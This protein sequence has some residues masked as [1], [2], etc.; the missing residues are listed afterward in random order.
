MTTLSRHIRFRALLPRRLIP[1]VLLRSGSLMTEQRDKQT[2]D[3]PQVTCRDVAKL[4]KSFF[5]FVSVDED[6]IVEMDSYDDRN[7]YI[8]GV[9]EEQDQ[10][11]KGSFTL[12]VTNRRESANTAL[13]EAQN[14]FMLYLLEGG[15]AAPRPL[16]ARGGGFIVLHSIALPNCMEGDATYA[17]RVFTFL[18]GELL[19]KVRQNPSLLVE[20]GK[21]IGRM[22]IHL[23]VSVLAEL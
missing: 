15:F 1:A 3:K 19:V 12:K 21:A 10:K 22:N 5:P 9:V 16:Q 4:A 11:T 17:I 14:D 23:K 7:F 2:Y 8:E 13:L 18:Q 6:S 20:L